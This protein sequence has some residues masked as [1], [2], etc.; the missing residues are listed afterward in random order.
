MR[1][2]KIGGRV[3]RDPR[4]ATTLAAEWLQAPGA[5]CVVHGGGDEVSA[6]QGR[7]GI[8]TTFVRG[9]RLTSAQ[10]L[11]L[12]RMALSGA[13]NKR[14]VS[15]LLDAGAPAV[16]ISGEDGALLLATRADPALGYVGNATAAN[17]APVRA[18]MNAGFLP[19]VSPLARDA[20]NGGPLNVN[21]DDAAAM[22]A[23]ALGAHELILVSDVSAVL[24]GGG[25]CETLDEYE[26]R[27]LIAS[28][29]ATGGMTPKLEAA[30]FAIARGVTMVRIGNLD[31]IGSDSSG[32]TIFAAAPVS[33]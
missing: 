3:Q 11:E 29:E 33:T 9:R 5:L 15:S 1:V 6:L 27:A 2:I 21:A 18:L 14:L 19:I 7:L 10:D 12:L 31:A 26:A 23:A 24:R 20:S 16:G 17:V 22:L 8:E 25:R 28:G 13:A 30:L 4:L 32:T